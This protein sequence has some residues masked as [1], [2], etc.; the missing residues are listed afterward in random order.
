MSA[1]GLKIFDSTLQTTHTWLDQ[2]LRE[3]E[4]DDKH[5]AWHALRAVLHTLRDRLPVN[6]MAQ[7]SAQLPL[8]IRGLLFEGWQ[9]S[10]SPSKER[11]WE[12]FV[13]H[14]GDS[15][16]LDSEAE[17]PQIVKAVFGV[18]ARHVSAG[19]VANIRHCLPGDFQRLWPK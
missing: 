11:H 2:I 6:E 17:G 12:E 3:L 10:R 7:F 18:I 19:E 8:L 15:F 4:W 14:V 16:V 9:P 1:T 13:A 5:K